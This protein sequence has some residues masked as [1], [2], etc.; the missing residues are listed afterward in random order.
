[1]KVKGKL[2]DTSPC[3]KGEAYTPML[4]LQVGATEWNIR[5]GKKYLFE[6]NAKAAAERLAKKLG[7]EIEWSEDE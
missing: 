3:Y 4:T 1:M 5:A 6:N 2:L 7:F